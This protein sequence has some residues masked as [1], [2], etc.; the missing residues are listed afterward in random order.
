[1]NGTQ[2]SVHSYFNKDLNKDI[3]ESLEESM[4]KI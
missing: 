1:M 4:K 3:I 2:L